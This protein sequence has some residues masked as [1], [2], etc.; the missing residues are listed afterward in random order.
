LNL[1]AFF[2]TNSAW[3]SNVY[4]KLFLTNEI[5]AVTISG[6]MVLRETREVAMAQSR[7][8]TALGGRGAAMVRPP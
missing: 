1:R 8:A 6:Y 2:Q 5:F 7:S 3:L 4:D